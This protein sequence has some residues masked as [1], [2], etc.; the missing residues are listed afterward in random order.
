MKIVHTSLRVDDEE[1]QPDDDLEY[2]MISSVCSA[3][4][5]I[6]LVSNTVEPLVWLGQD[7]RGKTNP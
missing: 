4:K 7:A 3:R 5:H 2:I 1:E 6:G